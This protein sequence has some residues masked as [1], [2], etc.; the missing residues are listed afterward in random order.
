MHAEMPPAAHE[1][2]R[3]T[4]AAQRAFWRRVLAVVVD[5]LVL[6]LVDIFINGIF[7]VTRVTGGSPIT[8]HSS[9]FTQFTASTDVG[10]GWLA[11]VWLV[12][13]ISLEALFGATVGKWV[14][15]LR[16]TDLEGIRPGLWSIVVRNVVRFVD[17]VP[18][19]FLVG[20]SVA[21]RAPRRQ[22]LGDHLARTLVIPRDA[23]AAPL[24]APAQ[25]RRCLALVGGVLLVCLAFSG[26]FFYYGRPPLVVQGLMNTR[27]MIFSD[28]VSAYTLSAPVWG[29]DTVTYQ[30]EYVTE[31]PTDTCHARLTLAWVLPTGWEPRTGESSCGPDRK[32]V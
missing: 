23:V 18:F 24:L 29:P 4:A 19:G 9:A 12:Y 25:L 26:A 5:L 6:S 22:R 10:W 14:V 3:L 2:A 16:V 13:Y 30:I 27:Q 1:T 32:G 7:G 8:A 11:L 15:D 20:G 31:H 28:G 17:G 21:L